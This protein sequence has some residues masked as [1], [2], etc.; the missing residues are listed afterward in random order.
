MG[1][2]YLK[3]WS[4]IWTQDIGEKMAIDMW[5]QLKLLIVATRNT[6]DNMEEITEEAVRK[7]IKVMSSGTAVG[8]DQWSPAQW[9]NLSPEALEAM[10]HLF[11]YIEKHGV[12][13]GY[14]YMYIYITISLR[15]WANQ[16]GAHAP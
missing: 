7:G 1:G 6:E 5:K 11:Q 2:Q 14:I 15:Q 12:W 16:L 13:P 8:T 10:A 4:G 3:D 9:K